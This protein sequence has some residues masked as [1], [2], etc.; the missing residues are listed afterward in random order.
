MS[1]RI[2]ELT[3][4]NFSP[5]IAGTGK[6][7]IHLDLNDIETR[8]IVL[9]G[10]IGSG[11]TYILSHLQPFA[12]VGTLDVRNA[13]DPIVSGKDGFKQIIYLKDD[14]ITYNIRHYYTANNNGSHSK[15]SYITKDGIELNPNGNVRTFEE[16]VLIEFGID[17]S[18]LRLIRIGNNVTNFINMHASERK[19]FIA[20]L[21]QD[22][23]VYLT[24]YK[25][26]SQ[27]LKTIN[28]KVTILMNKLASYGGI[29]IED[30]EGELESLE[31]Q[32]KQLQMDIDDKKQKQFELKAEAKSLLE[33]LTPKE[34]LQRKEDLKE[35]LQMVRKYVDDL[36]SSLEAFKDFPNIAQVSK[37]IGKYDSKLS[38]SSERLQKVTSEYEECAGELNSLLDRRVI[39][40]DEEHMK[41]LQD[42]YADLQ[43]Q[44]STYEKQLKGFQCEYSSTF[45]RNLLDT[46]NEMNV[47][48]QEI[49]QY[50]N[51]MIKKLYLADA[52]IRKFASDRIEI[53]SLRKMKIQKLI[54]NLHFAEEYEVP[55]NL[56]FPPFCPTKSC[57]Y[58][59]THP[60]TLK[61][62]L[63]E[64]DAALKQLELYQN[65]IRE[66]DV[67][68]YSLNEYPILYAKIASLRSYWEKVRPV[69]EKIRAL[70][71]DSLIK[72]LT[73]FQCQVWYNYD[74]IVDTIDLVEKRDIYYDLS[75][76]MK[77]IKNELTKLEL[78]KDQSLDKKIS[79][80]EKKRDTLAKEIE[81]A[82]KEYA[83]NEEQLKSYNEM[84]VEL[85]R[86]TQYEEQ[87]QESIT[88]R[89]QII[90]D[91]DRMTLHEEKINESVKILE[92][93]GQEI[94]LITDDLKKVIEKMDSLK[95]KMND[96][97]YA[98]KELK[99]LAKEQKWMTYMVD[100]VG[101]KKGIPMEMVKIFFDSCRTTINDMLYMVM[102]DD[103]E[104]LDF[105]IGEKDFL[106]PY[107]VNGYR[108][109]DISKASQGQMSL[110]STALSFALVK[111]LGSHAGKMSYP[112]PLLDEPD[113]PLHRSDKPKLISIIMNYLDDIGSE[114]CFVISHDMNTFDGYPVQIVMTTDELV[115]QERYADAI[116]I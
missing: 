107:M 91:T 33:G 72:I 6:D 90:R 68:I 20:S 22:S 86:K 113:A 18:F 89:D 63:K 53:L 114:Q 61:K 37:E 79:D 109:S 38:A 34:F 84:Y 73:I 71:T 54:N 49:T 82:E 87:L 4:E 69:L 42:S 13:D 96:M 112:I 115:N 11:K 5:I 99:G 105:D 45:L 98:M 78:A 30:L 21:L 65:E 43:K 81:D 67:E 94:L 106:I 62:N 104:L 24:L 55:E 56:Y 26:W 75:E 102:E 110:T 23:E 92:K 35:E 41:T 9:I 36:S 58:Y 1:L 50:D 108:T 77:N 74:R 39:S 76:K 83:K 46:I 17:S 29:S 60:Q 95:T 15:K 59:K 14:T 32:K 85:S 101:S 70:K 47:L 31:D 88:R 7:R 27:D 111:E 28:T 57:P 64:K 16:L 100:A 93:I 103:F 66:L 12:T 116:K 10:K 97:S 3:L 51:A 8:V 48:I 19:S 52:S 44:T 80:L 2:L 40:Q 25:Y